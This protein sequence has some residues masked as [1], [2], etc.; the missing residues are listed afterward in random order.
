MNLTESELVLVGLLIVYVAFF[1]NPIPQFL[2]SIFASPVG[3]AFALA[4]ILYVIT[5][6]SLIV[7]VFLAIAYIMT[8]KHVTE[9]LENPEKKDE[10]KEPAQPTSSGV[11][12][13]PHKGLMGASMVPH[14]EKMRLGSM[15]Q[16]KGTPPPA[17]PAEVAPPK[18]SHTT[19]QEHFADF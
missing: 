14:G 18:A 15:A 12:K 11:P 8:T 13:P 3:H 19:K 7:G 16:K 17:K 2:D 10:K 9:Y 5:S 1:T 6:Q 4:G